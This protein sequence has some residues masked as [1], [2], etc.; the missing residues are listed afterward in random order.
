MDKVSIKFRLNEEKANK[1]A[2]K[3]LKMY[4]INN[5]VSSVFEI[6]L[7]VSES[8]CTVKSNRLSSFVFRPSFFVLRLSLNNFVSSVF[9]IKLC[10]SVYIKNTPA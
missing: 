8:L 3:S 4:S 6:K 1:F 10:V 5:F 9:E 7:C 2:L